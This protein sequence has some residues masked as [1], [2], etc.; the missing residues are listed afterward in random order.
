MSEPRMFLVR[1]FQLF[2]ELHEAVNSPEILRQVTTDVVEE[3]SSDGVVYLELRTTLRPLPTYRDYLL[4][5]IEGVK[6]SPSV[7]TGRIVARLLISIDRARGVVN[8]QQ[9]VTLA[10]EAA[11]LWPELVMGVDLSG[12]PSVGS[13]LDYVSALNKA[14]ANGLKTTVHFAEL[15]GSASEWLQFLQ[16]HVPDRLGHVTSLSQTIASYH[17]VDALETR[18]MIVAAQIP[19]GSFPLVV[20][21]DV[22][23]FVSCELLA[24]LDPQL[25]TDD[26]G[27]FCSNLSNE[28]QL[29][30]EYCGLTE[31]D[32][33]RVCENAI[34]AAFCSEQVK[35]QLRK[36]LDLFR[37]R[38]PRF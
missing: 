31:T 8:G 38:V 37:A 3:F 32:V 13:L 5:V 4:G 11:R 19:L 2:R 35:S 10:I 26:K 14:R 18:K 30:V 21:N 1:C 16:Q 12:N 6:S 15:S 7:L 24:G 22:R 33:F 20:R 17:N 9:A 28:F 29:A 23:A 27:V 25:L 36:K 34:A